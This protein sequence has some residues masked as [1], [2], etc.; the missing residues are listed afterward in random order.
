MHYCVFEKAMSL[1]GNDEIAVIRE[2]P[3]KGQSSFQ[4]YSVADDIFKPIRIK[5]FVNNLDEPSKYCSKEG[6]IR[7]GLHKVEVVCRSVSIL[8]IEKKNIILKQA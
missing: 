3:H 4:V 7:F 1:V 8:T 6:E 5:A 2:L